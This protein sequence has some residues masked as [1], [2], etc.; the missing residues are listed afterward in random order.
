MGLCLPLVAKRRKVPFKPVLRLLRKFSP[1]RYN[2][3][4]RVRG[5]LLL[6]MAIYGKA[7]DQNFNMN[8]ITQ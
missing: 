4:G 3:G 1:I 7:E 8:D 6:T 2:I 5:W